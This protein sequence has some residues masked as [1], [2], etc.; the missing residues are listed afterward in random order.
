LFGRK[1]AVLLEEGIEY[2]PA[3]T[4]DPESFAGEESGKAIPSFLHFLTLFAF[5]HMC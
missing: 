1:M 4:R 2:S 5:S 3:L